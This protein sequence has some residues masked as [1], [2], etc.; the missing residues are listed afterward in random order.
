MTIA[1]RAVA[2]SSGRA[3]AE[4]HLWIA[5]IYR[6]FDAVVTCDDL[7]RGKPHPDIY[8]CAAKRLGVPAARCLA[9]EKSH[10][11]VRAA[12][13]AGM[14][15]VMVPDLLGPTDE[16]RA[17][18]EAVVPDLHA[19]RKLLRQADASRLRSS[20]NIVLL[21]CG[22]PARAVH[23]EVQASRPRNQPHTMTGH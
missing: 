15:V 13:G 23:R 18:C 3:R 11:G 5:G 17:K 8:L 20:R 14:Q 1:P 19:V 2:T 16:M 4:H 7:E 21:E 12:H 9:L 10:N 22:T 6:D